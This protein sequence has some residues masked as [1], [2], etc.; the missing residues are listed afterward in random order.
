MEKSWFQNARYGL[1]I[2]YGLYSLLG[3]GEW[4]MN[5]EQIP[6]GEYAK[7][8]ERF[9]AEK[10]DADDII[11]RARDWGM[12]YAVLTTKHHDG[13]CLYDSKLTDFIAPKSA[14][15]RDLVAEFVRACHKYGLKIGL[16]HSLNDM[17]TSPDA[18]DALE[19]PGE[20]YQPFIDYVH[21]QIREIMTNYGKID[22]M[23]YDG[24]WPFDAEGWQ[25]EKLNE[26][27]RSLQPDILVNSRCGLPGDFDTPEGH[28]TSSEGMWEACMTL[29][30]NWGYHKGDHNWKSAKTVAVMLQ[31]AAAGAGNLLLNIGP[32]G[33]GSIPRES[34]DILDK[35]GKWLKQ[36]GDA[37]FDSDRFEY[38]LR[39]RGNERS[40]HSHHGL[41][42]ARGNNCY[43]H[44]NSWP[45]VNLVISGL[46]CTVIAVTNLADG[47]SY[48]FEQCE[49]IITVKSL[50]EKHNTDMPVVLRFRTK[51][52]PCIY[53]SGG[54]RNPK[55]PHCR[56][57]PMP[58]DVRH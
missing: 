39:E 28:I 23:W 9:T 45:G 26:M 14:A 38:N 7:L 54:H 51:D 19:R 17:S 41:Y 48:D 43:L 46:E 58:S 10:Y 11:R 34:I 30:N 50:P 1:F 3:R 20:C 16:Y 55:V 57:D 40:D 31:Q 22:I 13:F 4:V 18:V 21:G 12:R 6:V 53:R 5:K 35:V 29:N 25:A 2:H 33:N 27:V 36:N 49:G 24:W 47:T 8:A 56:Y 44:L 32:K 52:T 37:I 15:K 42:T